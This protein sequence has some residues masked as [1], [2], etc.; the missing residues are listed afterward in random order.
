MHQ[1]E[2]HRDSRSFLARFWLSYIYAQTWSRWRRLSQMGRS[3][4]TRFH[5]SNDRTRIFSI[6]TKLV[7][8]SQKVWRP[9]TIEITFW[10]QSSVVYIKPF[11][12]RIWRTTTQTANLVEVP[13]TATVIEFFFHLVAM[14]WILVVITRIQRKSNEED[15]CKGSW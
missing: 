14:E 13:G 5:L 2:I 7:D 6:Q 15:A 4:R 10:L 9:R 11:T 1:E 12:P 3:C 8:L